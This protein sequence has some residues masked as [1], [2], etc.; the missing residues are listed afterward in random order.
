M[1]TADNE[2][3]QPE[4]NTISSTYLQADPQSPYYLWTWGSIMQ[5][6]ALLYTGLAHLWCLFATRM[7]IQPRAPMPASLPSPVPTAT[8]S[9]PIVAIVTGSN[10]GIGF[11]T[12]KTLVLD[13]GWHVILACR[14]KDKALQAQHIIQKELDQKQAATALDANSGKPIVLDQ[15]LDLSDFSSIDLFVKEVEDRYPR[16]HMLINNAGRNTSGM[17]PTH[18]PLDLLFQSN[19][20]GHFR[21]T[22][23]LIQSKRLVFDD[24][25]VGGGVVNL[26]SVMHHFCGPYVLNE[27]YWKHVGTYRSSAVDKVLTSAC[28]VY[29]EVKAA[30]SY[31]ASKVAA[32]FFTL[33]LNR[34]YQPTTTTSKNRIVSVAVNP[35]ATASDIWRGFPTYVQQIMKI[36]F[37]TPKQ[38]S[39]PV[40]AA[41]VTLVQQPQQEPAPQ[42][43]TEFGPGKMGI[44][45]QPYWQPVGYDPCPFP[46][47]EILGPY[48]GYASTRPRLPL[49]EDSAKQASLALWKVSTELACQP[50]ISS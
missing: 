5:P 13:Y 11:E 12:A 14:S 49:V 7:Q 43:Y 8:S 28:G 3:Q 2:P 39:V 24:N 30:S 37:L 35:G 20:L 1:S 17:S 40:V 23:G 26:S 48:I 15:P 34:R 41:A 22:M 21:L 19:F 50:T 45:L 27:M 29:R 44:Y 9:S 4:G 42:S 33:E 16:I 31:C 32:I 25:Q 6:M 38:A 46:V 47:T 18:P 36:I 10:T